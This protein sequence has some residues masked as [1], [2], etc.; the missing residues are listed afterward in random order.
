MHACTGSSAMDTVCNDGAGV[1][2]MYFSFRRTIH[3]YGNN[4]D[5]ELASVLLAEI[6]NRLEQDAVIFNNSQ[7]TIK[8]IFSIIFS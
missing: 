7:T 4:F 6:R 2:Y 5:R 8:A 1:Y 3:K